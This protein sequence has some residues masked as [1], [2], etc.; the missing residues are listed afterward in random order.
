MWSMRARRVSA[1]G[2]DEVVGHAAGQEAD[3]LQL[4][5]LQELKLQLSNLVLQ[6]EALHREAER[7]ARGVTDDADQP[8]LR[9]VV[10]RS[11]AHLDRYDDAVAAYDLGRE[12]VGSR[13]RHPFEVLA[14][15]GPGPRQAQARH[16]LAA[17]GLR[18][19]A[20]DRR[21][22]PGRLPDSA[23]AVHEQH[24]VGGPLEGSR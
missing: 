4:L 11:G 22:R 20:E 2:S 14:E 23:L 8:R 6:A 16:G 15:D 1:S 9:R 13:P 21:G 17:Q 7:S 5:G 3:R 12:Q 18:A 24:G 19:A 10:R